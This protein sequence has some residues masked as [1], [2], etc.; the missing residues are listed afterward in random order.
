MTSLVGMEKE[1]QQHC[2]AVGRFQSKESC[3]IYWN[4]ERW[5]GRLIVVIGLSECSKGVNTTNGRK[6][7]RTNERAQEQKNKRKTLTN[8]Q[9][10][11]QINEQISKIIIKQTN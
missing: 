1:I 4:Q 8:E 3:F 2:E 7:E 10:N 9:S 6:N 11:K 5:L